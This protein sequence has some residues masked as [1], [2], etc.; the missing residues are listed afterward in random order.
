MV[1]REGRY[2]PSCITRRIQTRSITRNM[3]NTTRWALLATQIRQER[4]DEAKSRVNQDL[5]NPLLNRREDPME[6]EEED[7]LEIPEIQEEP[8]TNIVPPP[9]EN[10]QKESVLPSCYMVGIILTLEPI[11]DL[12]SNLAG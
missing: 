6:I 2:I 7:L 3:I 10:N 11:L 4:E 9:E 8:L 12:L 1:A 5:K